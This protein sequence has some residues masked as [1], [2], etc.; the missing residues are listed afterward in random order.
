VRLGRA[1][2][3]ADVDG[4]ASGAGQP[5][6]EHPDRRGAAGQGGPRAPGHLLAG[7]PAAQGAQVEGADI[8]GAEPT[9]VVQQAGDVGEIGPDGVWREVA[10]GDEV[11]LVLRQHADHR[12]G[13]VALVGGCVL[14]WRL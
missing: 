4:D 11:S 9:G 8:G 13:E 1:Q 3:G 10:L 2:A 7:Q 5:G 14:R 6:G 12:L